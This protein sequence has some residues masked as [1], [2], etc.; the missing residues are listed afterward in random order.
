MRIAGLWH[1]TISIATFGAYIECHS[2]RRW[3]LKNDALFPKN[4]MIQAAITFANE[5]S[6]NTICTTKNFV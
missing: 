1:Y 6:D 2:S 4:I 5:S 3:S